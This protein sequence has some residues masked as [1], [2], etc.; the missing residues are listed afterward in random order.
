MWKCLLFSI[1]LMQLLCDLDFYAIQCATL[2]LLNLLDESK[3]YEIIH[4][5]VSATIAWSSRQAIMRDV[6][7]ARTPRSCD[8]RH[9]LLRHDVAR[10]VHTDC[11]LLFQHYNNL[12]RDFFLVA[13]PFRLSLIL[14]LSFSPSLVGAW[15]SRSSGFLALTCT[16]DYEATHRPDAPSNRDGLPTYF[17]AAR[18]RS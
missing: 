17:H 7:F 2:I 15:Q 1:L 11:G 13:A 4:F 8:A 10:L 18:V 16:C 12:S 14:S 6:D 9:A 3:N 5:Q